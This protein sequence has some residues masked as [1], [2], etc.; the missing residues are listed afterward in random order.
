MY[1]QVYIYIFIYVYLHAGGAEGVAKA[2]EIINSIAA[3]SHHEVTHPG[4]SH[5]E[6]D[7]EEWQQAIRN[8]CSPICMWFWVGALRSTAPEHCGF[9]V[10]SLI[11]EV[12]ASIMHLEVYL[13]RPASTKQVSDV[14]EQL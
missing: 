8:I 14:W 6:M 10:F 4:L 7:L 2:K 12:L 3:W 13:D 1:I 5:V 9:M 11:Y